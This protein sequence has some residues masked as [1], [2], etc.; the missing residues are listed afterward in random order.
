MLGHLDRCIVSLE[1][2]LLHIPTGKCQVATQGMARD[3]YKHAARTAALSI[4]N[5]YSS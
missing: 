2:L 4:S 1:S 3:L 5:V